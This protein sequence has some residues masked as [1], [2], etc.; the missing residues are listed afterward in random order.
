[1]SKRIFIVVRAFQENKGSYAGVI[2]EISKRLSKQ[3]KITI[4]CAKT[5]VKE[6][7]YEKLSYA[8]VYRFKIWRQRIP[9]IG[10]N[11][12]YLSLAKSV[13]IFFR[14]NPP[15]KED[16]IIAN[17]RAALGV[18]NSTYILR[19]GQPAF[20][21]LKN[22][23][24]A[25]SEVT[26]VTRVARA[27]HFTYQH[28][29]ENKC[30]KN[31][32][33]FIVSSD[34]SM[35]EIYKKYRI[36]DKR[37]ILPHGGV[38]FY[39]FQSTKGQKKKEKNILFI[40]AGTEKIRKGVVYLEKAIP[41][42]FEKH[43]DVTLLHVGEKFEWN[44]PEWCK[45]RIIQKGRIPWEEMKNQY[46][47]ASLFINCALNEWIPHTIFEAMCSG[48]PVVTSDIEGIKELFI[49]KTDTFIYSR[50]DVKGI[51]T[52]VDYILNNPHV[53]SNI[54]KMAK[55]K[56]K[57]LDYDNYTKMLNDFLTNDKIIYSN[58]L[59]CDILKK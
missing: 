31:A 12:D 25:K 24:I 6:R 26:I 7:K 14:N 49:H 41:E 3:Y 38:K 27:I 21:F 48:L 47:N 43:K 22:M 20:T 8:E 58:V 57:S 34:E 36:N 42:I 1:M 30:V 35:Q 54:S 10:M 44:V 2:E 4:L 16:I 59:L 23:E 18:L 29:L 9:L 37:Y 55:L 13:K 17:G 32:S 52:G 11:N 19:M 40:S 15:K 28:F 56:V 45:K 50:G 53:A 46:Q 33:A 39:E 51:I 5:D